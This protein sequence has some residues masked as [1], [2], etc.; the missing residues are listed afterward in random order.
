MREIVVLSGKGG[1]GKTSVTA[2]FAALAE[3]KVVCDLDVDAPDLHILLDPKN[4]VAE[5]FLSG[6]LA[7]VERTD[8]DGCGTCRD[9]CRFGAVTLG[10]G[11]K[12]VVDPRRCEGCKA[13]VALCPRQAIAFPP[14]VCGYFARSE[15]RFGPF[16]HARL[17]PGGENSGRLV[18]LLKRNA[19]ELAEKEG[20]ELILCDGAPG[21]ACPV[22]S[23][24]SGATLAVLVTEPTPSGIHD[25][26][27]VA[28]LCDHFRL[29]VGVIVNKADVNPEQA[30][31]LEAACAEKGRVVLGRLPY[32]PDVTRA[33]KAR[34]TLPEYGGPLGEE[35]AR[36]WEAANA[37]AHAC[38]KAR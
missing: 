29:P 13:C 34:L 38:A 21:I 15:T 36:L 25:L 16:V 32:S 19:R 11:G 17:D 37:L 22:I 5:E 28:E 12:A 18:A 35:I 26:L 31:R 23:S 9:V 14:R 3:N 2:A 20:H 33:M 4:T 24:L 27:R 1:A 7:L 6:N 30:D 8:C 10:A